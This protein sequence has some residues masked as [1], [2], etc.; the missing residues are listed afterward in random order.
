MSYFG[1][2]CI[3]WILWLWKT[4]KYQRIYYFQDW[5]KLEKIIPQNHGNDLE[6][7]KYTFQIMEMLTIIKLWNC[8]S[9]IN[10]YQVSKNEWLDVALC[11][12]LV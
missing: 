10:F 2:V 4:W 8:L 5:K 1:Q 9:L 11:L 6:M 3:V 7:E 12:V